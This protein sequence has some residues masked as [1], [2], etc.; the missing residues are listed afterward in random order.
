MDVGLRRIGIAISPD[1]K[2]AVP[3]NPV[4]RKNREQAA[5]DV[6]DF[7]KE[8]GIDTLVVGIPQGSSHEEMKRRIK[9][10]VSL[11]DFDGEIHYI[12][13]DFSSHEAK[14]LTKGLMRHKKDGKL[15]SIAAAQI[16]ERWFLGRKGL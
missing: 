15:D 13:E 12:D 4:I 16:L 2:I 7:L 8:W 5:K 9:H 6:S 14:E 1:G 11:L 10:F 3:Q